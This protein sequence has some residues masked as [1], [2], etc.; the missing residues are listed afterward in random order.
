MIEL[1]VLY[2]HNYHDINLFSYI[3]DGI[4]QIQIQNIIAG[5][6][7][8][9]DD[10]KS[11][12]EKDTKDVYCAKTFSVANL[13]VKAIA[14][15]RKRVPLSS[16]KTLKSASQVQKN[17]K[18]HQRI[19]HR[20]F[21]KHLYQFHVKQVLHEMPRLCGLLML[22]CQAILIDQVPRKVTCFVVCFR[23]VR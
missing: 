8:S 13:G 2:F 17:L 6:W 21:S 23:I 18:N 5:A 4:K 7:L 10:F 1:Q 9:S 20:I 12:L 15:H 3:V 16:Q 19:L 14:S 11:W 22:F